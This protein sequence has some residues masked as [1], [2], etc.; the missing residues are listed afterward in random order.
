VAGGVFLE[1]FT[2]A[3]IEIGERD[4]QM[5]A[6]A[7]SASRQQSEGGST[8]GLAD[9]PRDRQRQTPADC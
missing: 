9:R 6:D 4:F 8:E 5:C 7:S 3:P 1:R 2:L